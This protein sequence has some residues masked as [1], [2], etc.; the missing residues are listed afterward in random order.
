VLKV[1]GVTAVIVAACPTRW[2][3]LVDLIGGVLWLAVARF[4]D[5]GVRKIYNVQVAGMLC[6]DKCPIGVGLVGLVP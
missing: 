6:G 1:I 5:K 4:G 3:G 2:G